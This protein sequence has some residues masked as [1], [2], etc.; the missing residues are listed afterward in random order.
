M[1]PAKSA[2]EDYLVSLVGRKLTAVERHEFSWS[3]VFGGAG[4]LTVEGPWRVR[5]AGAIVLS[6]L[7]HQQK[8]G[9]PEP[10]DAQLN[11]RQKILGKLVRDISAYDGKGDLT[12]RFEDDFV[13]EVFNLSTGYEAWQ[14]SKPQE[15]TLISM[16]GGKLV[17]R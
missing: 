17:F 8:L 4:I 15:A 6:S 11:A 5:S 10:V 7:D 3:F 13:L 14:I 12:V 2:I 9:L 16:G 1:S